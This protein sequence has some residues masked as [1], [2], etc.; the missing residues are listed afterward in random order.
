MIVVPA[1][2]VLDGKVVR[3]A[4]GRFGAATVYGQ[5]PVATAAHWVEQGATLVHVVDLDGAR[6]GFPDPTLWERLG[7]FGLPFQVG[8]GLRSVDAVTASIGAGATRVVVGTTAIW[9]SDVLEEMLAAVGPD[10]VVAAIDVREGNVTGN[11]WRDGGRP[12]ARV[13]PDL[14]GRG[15]VRAL[16]TAIASDGK[17]AGPDLAL[18]AHLGRLAPDMALLASGGVGTLGDLTAL[19]ASGRFEATI[20]GRALYEERFTLAAAR[21]AAGG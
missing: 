7:S 16:V 6:R 20:V 2:D 15:V 9:R 13:V 12:V 19:A 3:L 18:L 5:D 14:A 1:V 11:G 4:G 17:M 8:G 21:V 10:R